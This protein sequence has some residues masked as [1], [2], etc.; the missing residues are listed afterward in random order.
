MAYFKAVQS[1]IC[2]FTPFDLTQGKKLE[3]YGCRNIISFKDRVSNVTLKPRS[4][5]WVH[6]C[7]Q[8]ILKC[9][10]KIFS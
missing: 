3:F 10:L 9:A 7:D 4:F 1:G 5:S 8:R 2:V 6:N